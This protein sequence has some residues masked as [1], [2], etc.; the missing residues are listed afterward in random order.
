MTNVT[1]C[2]LVISMTDVDKYWLESTMGK[3][4]TKTSWCYY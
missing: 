4:G 3:Q 1:Y 2:Y